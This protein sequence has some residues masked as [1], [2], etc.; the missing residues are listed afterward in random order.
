M[1]FP[2]GRDEQ[3]GVEG[4]HRERRGDEQVVLLEES[5]HPIVVGEAFAV[6]ASE[7]PHAVGEAVADHRDETGVQA[8]LPLVHEVAEHAGEAAREQAVFHL[9]R[10][11]PARVHF[12]DVGAEFL[13]GSRRLADQGRDIGVDTQIAEIGTV[14]DAQAG[15][16]GIEV[17]QIVF[18][19]HAEAGGIAIVRPRHRLQHEG[20]VTHRPGHRTHVRDRAV[21]RHGPV[22]DA[23]VG[24]L[25]SVDAA[26]R[27]RHA[28]GACAVRS[29]VD[30]TDAG[31]SA[32]RGT[33]A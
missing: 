29:L 32:D 16:A 23:P 2:V 28:D 25:E 19:G 13:E 7:V 27:R 15:D 8:I 5:A 22:G 24:R 4:R 33:G 12:L 14:G 3:V 10:V 11:A 6:G 1:L 17:R 20:G 18:G 30:R 31:G 26:E 9:D 21:V